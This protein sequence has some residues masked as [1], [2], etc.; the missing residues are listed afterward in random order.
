[1]KIFKDWETK[2]IES[3][4]IFLGKEAILQNRKARKLL[5]EFEKTGDIDC[6]KSTC[7]QSGASMEAVKSFSIAKN[8]FKLDTFN[9]KHI[10]NGK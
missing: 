6:L 10:N 1:M 9:R 3:F 8:Y 5:K 7:V 2:Q 4:V